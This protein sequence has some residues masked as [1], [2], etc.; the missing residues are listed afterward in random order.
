MHNRGPQ[1]SII[2]ITEGQY[3]TIQHTTTTVTEH[4]IDYHTVNFIE[5]THSPESI[6]PAS[7]LSDPIYWSELEDYHERYDHVRAQPSDK[8]LRIMWSIYSVI[9]SIFS[10][11]IIIIFLGIITN[12]QVRKNPFNKFLL[13]LSFPDLVYTFFCGVFTCLPSAVHGGFASW[14]ICK[15]Q[16]FYLFWGASSNSWI[17]G[18]MAYEI[19]RLLKSSQIRKRYFPPTDQQVYRMSAICYTIAIVPATLPLIANALKAEEYFPTPGIQSGFLCE[20]TEM[21]LM[22]TLMFWFVIAPLA[23]G[24]PYLFVTYV[25]IDV[26][27]SKLLPPRGRRRDLAIYFFR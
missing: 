4:P 6:M 14:G 3:K 23:F 16:V 12:R 1:G 5:P 7:D 8:D 26:M 13:F 11:G 17:N 22:S 21:T 18:V 9:L 27:Y 25:L 20:P 15:F 19:H 2:N 10:L 24:I